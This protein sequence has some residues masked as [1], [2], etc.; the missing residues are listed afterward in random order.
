MINLEQM[1]R[2]KLDSEKTDEASV[3]NDKSD[4]MTVK[5]KHPSYEKMILQTFKELKET[6]KGK[7][8]KSV[9]RSAVANHIY[10][11]HFDGQR[12][13]ALFLTKAL[14]KMV[15]ADLL[16]K[17]GPSK[18]ARYLLTEKKQTSRPNT[19][20]ASV[21]TKSDQD[22]SKMDDSHFRLEIEE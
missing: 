14:K 15:D 7:K 6:L 20:S 18:Q 11:V 19:R 10:K 8:T 16:T 4:K 12:Q 9:T 5:V 3:Q 22:E 13:K 17:T 21:K 1:N 2:S